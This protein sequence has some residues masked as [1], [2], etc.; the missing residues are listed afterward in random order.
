[1][2]GDT[3]LRDILAR[4]AIQSRQFCDEVALLGRRDQSEPEFFRQLE[5][6]H[7]CHALCTARA[8]ELRKFLE[9]K[10]RPKGLSA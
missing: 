1:M 3:Q 9:E 5:E 4:Y 8:D 2:L 6:V 10:A 7:K